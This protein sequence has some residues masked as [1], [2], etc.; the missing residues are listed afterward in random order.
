MGGRA[1]WAAVV[2]GCWRCSCVP[3]LL[4]PPAP[5]PLPPDVGLPRVGARPLEPRSSRTP[6]SRAG[7]AGRGC[8]ARGRSLRRRK[9]IRDAPVPLPRA[10]QPQRG[11]PSPRQDPPAAACPPRRPLASAAAESPRVR[12]GDPTRRRSHRDR[13]RAT[14]PD[15]ARRHSRPRLRRYSPSPFWQPHANMSWS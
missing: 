5:P 13:R 12:P 10:S 8:A 1:K 11:T 4:K 3:S 15:E 9:R 7:G 2:A 14:R 6:R